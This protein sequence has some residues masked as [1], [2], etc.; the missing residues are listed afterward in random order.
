MKALEQTKDGKAAGCDEIPVEFLRVIDENNLNILL[1]LC[2]RMNDTGQF[3][4]DW[5]KATFITLPKKANSKTC[6]ELD[7]PHPQSAAM[8]RE[9]H[10]LR[11][12]SCYNML[13]S[14]KNV[15]ACFVDY[16]KAFDTIN[17]DK[18]I[19]LSH[20]SELD[21]KNIQMIQNVYWNQYGD[22]KGQDMSIARQSCVLSYYCS[23]PK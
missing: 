19:E 22:I 12:R 5:L 8:E 14:T 6:N 21:S 18:L 20:R 11:C 17:H 2:N 13:R 9:S 23:T 1:H 15:F 7:E 4:S 3:L 10:S 16:E